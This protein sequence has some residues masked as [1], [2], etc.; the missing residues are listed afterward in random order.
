VQEERTVVL[1]TETPRESVTIDNWRSAR[2]QAGDLHV[3]ATGLYTT[4][5]AAIT[6]VK[7]A[8][9]ATYE[10][11]ARA[12]GWADRIPFTALTVGARLCAYSTLDRYAV[13]QVE[14]VPSPGGPRL[15]FYGRTW[16]H[17]G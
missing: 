5:G 14:S 3:D 17:A 1:S 16:E 8:V 13:L 15:I 4:T 12:T 9:P 11:C 2:D 7:K 10:H 6:L